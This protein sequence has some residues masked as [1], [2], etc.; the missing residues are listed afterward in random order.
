MNIIETNLTFGPLSKRDK[1]T[2]MYL[3]HAAT[4]KCTVEQIHSWHKA[5]GW[6]GI[7]YHYLVCKDGSIYR[8]RPEDTIGAHASGHNSYSIGIC[9][10]GNFE[11]EEMP[12]AQKA[13]GKELIAYLKGKYKIDKV[14]R[15]KDVNA[16]ACPGKHFPFEEIASA[17]GD[18]EMVQYRAHLQTYDWQ[19]TK[20]EG[21]IAGTTGQGKR[22]EAFVINSDDINFKYKAHI[23]SE[24]DTDWVTNGHV[25]G[26]MGLGKRIEAIWIDADADIR[27]RVHQQGAGWTPWVT[28]G[29]MAGATGRSKRIEAIQIE[30]I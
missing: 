5:F 15:H 9:F 21:E 11:I 26:T 23:Q 10:E 16:T 8:G 1:T 24:G 30:V 25:V 27:Y 4:I 18:D 12:E 17:K 13:A 14:L 6:P 7:G 28:N 22:M 2:E 19:D 20:Q 3:H 29:Q